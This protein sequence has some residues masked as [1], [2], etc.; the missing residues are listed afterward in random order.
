MFVLSVPMLCIWDTINKD[1]QKYS[2]TYSLLYLQ[3]LS[4]TDHTTESTGPYGVRTPYG[5]YRFG[6]FGTPAETT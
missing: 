4:T 6:T 3:I 1:C 5:P 2:T